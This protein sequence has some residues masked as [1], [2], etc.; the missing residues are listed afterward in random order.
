MIYICLCSVFTIVF[1]T[2]FRRTWCQ[3]RW[4]FAVTSIELANAALR[5][6]KDPLLAYVIFDLSLAQHSMGVAAKIKTISIRRLHNIRATTTIHKQHMYPQYTD[7]RD[8]RLYLQVSW[9]LKIELRQVSDI[10]TSYT[11]WLYDM[12]CRHV[13]HCGCTLQLW[14]V[15]NW[16]IAMLLTNITVG[17]IT[18][19]ITGLHWQLEFVC[20][21]IHSLHNALYFVMPPSVV[22]VRPLHYQE[23]APLLH[24]PLKD[25]TVGLLRLLLLLRQC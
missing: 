17:P 25:M 24:H 15:T 14:S 10:M 23:V 19:P 9:T 7:C 5:I 4:A 22:S 3:C 6:V 20:S 1:I 21:S 16:N 8:G 2:L 18:G 13:T 12:K 11:E